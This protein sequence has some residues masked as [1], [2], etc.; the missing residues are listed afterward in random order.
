MQ[1]RY[2]AEEVSYCNSA[3][4]NRPEL[5]IAIHILE[6]ATVNQWKDFSAHHGYCLEHYLALL[7]KAE[8]DRRAR[9]VLANQLDK[10]PFFALALTAL[11]RQLVSWRVRLRARYQRAGR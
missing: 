3:P 1:R 10:A 2:S 4:R 5:G 8:Q 11:G 6:E 7:D 9:A